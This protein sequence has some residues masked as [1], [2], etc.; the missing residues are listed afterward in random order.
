M[1]V[2]R[3]H[4]IRHGQTD[5]NAEGRWQ[6]YQPVPLNSEGWSRARALASYL[7]RCYQLSAIVSSD[8]P[9]AWQ[10]ASVLASAYKLTPKADERLREHDLGIFQ[11]YT[12]AEIK[13]HYP[14]EIT[15]APTRCIT[16]FPAANRA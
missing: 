13:A 11:G 14:V 7:P 10:T 5:W 12:M 4:L 3:V 6:G 1:V 15:S 16:S 8:L 9:R 2:Q